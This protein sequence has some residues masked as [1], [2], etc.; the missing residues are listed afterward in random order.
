MLTNTMTTFYYISHG[1]P[2]Q[3]LPNTNSHQL[4]KVNQQRLVADI[5]SMGSQ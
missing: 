1:N 2:L 4:L 5:Q 3:E